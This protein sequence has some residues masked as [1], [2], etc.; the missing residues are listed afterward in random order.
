MT[1][2]SGPSVRLAR[3]AAA[4]T[5]VT[6][7]ALSATACGDSVG[8]TS[9]TGSGSASTLTEIDYYEAAPQNTQ[10]PKLL[11]EC[12]AQ[13]GVKIEHQQVPRAQFMPKL[14][15]Q[16]SS[17]AMPD[18]ALIDNPDLPQLA[19]TGGLLPL[20]DAGLTTEGLYPSIVEAGQFQG[21][22]YGIAPGVNGLALY[23]NKDAFTEAGLTPPK[24]W[25]DLT[26][27][28]RALTKGPRYG[29]AFSA[30]GTEEGSFQFEP[31]F[32]TA[33][34]S[35]KQLDS[36]QAVQALTLWKDLVDGKSASKSVVTWTQADVNDQF[37]AG[38]AAMMVNG[39]WQ[40]PTLNENKDLHFG[41]VP[42]PIPSP[43]AKP[44]TPLGGE[45][46]TVGH[47][48]PAREKNAVAVLK[49]LLSQDKSLEWSTNAGYIPS[50]QA[51][52]EQMSASNPQLAAFV[53]E[54][55]TAR[56]RTAELGTAY[57]KASEALFN[58]IQASLAGGTPP[59]EALTAAQDAAA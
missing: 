19:A 31:F 51:A 14:L 18:L 46:W 39:P 35:L 41:I 38:N 50:N 25:D 9:G 33:G 30:V 1:R 29:I 54:V 2:I 23:Y 21:K 22:T 26:K 44:V 12:G 36:P 10:L 3:R 56:A 55:A 15:Q 27:A 20:S 48:D 42:I 6:V 16:A 53:E 40:L 17:R 58:A 43:E 24:T 45:V 11:D 7:T 37:M 57:P 52:A 59:Q 8:D 5:V 49:C 34:A 4:V 13:V 28:A 32:W 47:S